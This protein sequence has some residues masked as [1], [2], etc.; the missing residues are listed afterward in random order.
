MNKKVKSSFSFGQGLH[1]L[2]FSTLLLSTFP[3][4]YVSSLS[5]IN[6]IQLVLFFIPS[7]HL[8]LLNKSFSSF[9]LF[10]N[11]FI[12]FI[13]FWL[14]WVFVAVCRLSLFAASGGYSL[15]WCAGFSLRWLLLLRSTDSRL[16]GFSCCVTWAQQWWHTGLVAPRMWDLPRPGLEPVSPALAG[17]F[18]TTVPPEKPSSFTLNVATVC[19]I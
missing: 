12:Y 1:G 8:C 2:S 4:P 9:I 15:L 10:F 7:D 13:Y 17:G 18:L 11:K 19:C 6:S 14:H 5:L 16:A 3:Y